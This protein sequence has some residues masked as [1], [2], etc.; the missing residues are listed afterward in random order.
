M[1]GQ[2]CGRVDQSE[3]GLTLPLAS[4][5]SLL[6]GAGSGPG[7]GARLWLRTPSHCYEL[8]LYLYNNV[9]L[10]IVIL[11]IDRIW[12][13]EQPLGSPASCGEGDGGHQGGVGAL[14]LD[15]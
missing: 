14:K 7:A 1:R 12:E 6:P 13:Q 2:Y 9:F 15:L 4:P 10:V 5:A 11:T 3:A 8:I